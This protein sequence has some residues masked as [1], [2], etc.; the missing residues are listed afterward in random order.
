MRIVIDT[1]VALMLAGILAGVTL[2]AREREDDELTAQSLRANVESLNREVQLRAA[3]GQVEL[4]EG[5]FP[6]TIDPEWFKEGLPRNPMLADGRPWLEVAPIEQRS[7]LHPPDITPGSK[8]TA[9]FWYNPYQGVVRA[10]VPAG[11][12]DRRTLQ[13]Y[14]A[15]NG[16]DLASRFPAA[17]RSDS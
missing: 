14:N 11:Q 16:T 1:L 5:G 6:K 9:S 3:L 10:R 7:A 17:H 15:V 4:S 8:L 2:H 12:S 13:T